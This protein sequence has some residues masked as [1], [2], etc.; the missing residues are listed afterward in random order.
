MKAWSPAL[1][2]AQDR[3][4]T[5]NNRWRAPVTLLRHDYLKESWIV[6]LIKS[7]PFVVSAWDSNSHKH[8]MCTEQIVESSE[9]AARIP[10]MTLIKIF[11]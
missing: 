10:Q 2:A 1:G 5:I 8:N 9:I 7:I 6:W 4:S 11:T 3:L